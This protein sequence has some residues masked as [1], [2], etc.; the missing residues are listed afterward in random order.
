MIYEG[1]RYE[2][3]MVLPIEDNTGVFHATVIL[4]RTIVPPTDYT[5]HRIVYGDRLDLLAA[6][7]YGDPELWWRI[8][9]ANPSLA[10]PDDLPLGE[11]LKI[12]RLAVNL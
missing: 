5:V 11:L 6:R 4:Q 12:P 10:F 9:D 1:S 7:A 8:A 3:A 2:S